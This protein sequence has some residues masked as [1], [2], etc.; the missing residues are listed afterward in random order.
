MT[1]SAES[2][3]SCPHAAQRLDIAVA[4]RGAH[5]PGADEG[6]IADDEIRLP[7]MSARR[8]LM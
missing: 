8:G 6:R 4:E 1:K 5:R 2:G 3:T 7:A